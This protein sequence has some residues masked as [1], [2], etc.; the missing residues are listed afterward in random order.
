MFL[1][2]TP[3]NEELLAVCKFSNLPSSEIAALVPLNMVVTKK[4]RGKK[5]KTKHIKISAQPTISIQWQNQFCNGLYDAVTSCSGE[6]K[7]QRVP[8]HIQSSE[9]C[10]LLLPS[11]C[12]SLQWPWQGDA[13]VSLSL[14][15]SRLAVTTAVCWAQGCHLLHNTGTQV[16]SVYQWVERIWSLIMRG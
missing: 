3:K 16:L 13:K 12:L 5:P 4:G 9:R 1:Y 14:P 2:N 15:Q 6:Q 7:Q 10:G 8:R 11:S